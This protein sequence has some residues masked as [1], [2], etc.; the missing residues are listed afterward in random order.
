MIIT[1]S[2]EI[3]ILRRMN[4]FNDVSTFHLDYLIP[5]YRVE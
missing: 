1:P 5:V 4:Q 3:M 2:R